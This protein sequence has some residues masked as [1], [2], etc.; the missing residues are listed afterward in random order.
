MSIFKESFKPGIKTQIKIRENALG[1]F[2]GGRGAE[3]M[4]YYNSRNA[5]I[6]MQS[7]V[8]V[9]GTNDLAKAYILQGGALTST[10]NIRQS[11]IGKEGA[12][13]TASPSGETYRLGIRP[14]PGITSIDVKS[15]SAFGSLRE[16]TVKYQCWDIKQLE[17]LELLYMRP[18]YTALVEWGWVPYLDNS[19]KLQST[20]AHSIP[21]ANIAAG[22]TKEAI[23]ND[24]YKYS[25]MTG[26]YDAVYGFIKNYQWSARADGGY[27]CTTTIITMGEILE[28]LKINYGANDTTAQEKGILGWVGTNAFLNID[29]PV[30]KAYAINI[31]AGMITEMYQAAI[32]GPGFE[33]PLANL[34]PTFGEGT[35]N[36]PAKGYA[37]NYG[38]FRWDLN[39]EHGKNTN[40]PFASAAQIYCRLKDF[41]D[42]LNKNILIHDTGANGTRTKPI[43]EISLEESYVHQAG[44]SPLLCLSHPFQLSTDPSV[45]IIKNDRWKDPK[46]YFGI[47]IPGNPLVDVMGGLKSTF[48][49]VNPTNPDA[50]FGIIGNIYVNLGFLYSLS[51]NGELQ[52][53]DKKEKN[54]IV[55][56]DYLKAVLA[57]VN[58][59][60]G[61]VANL[62][63]MVDPVDSVARIID[64]NYV[65]LRKRDDVYKD[66][67]TFELHNTRSIVRSYKLE[68]QIFPEQSTI[69]AIGA[70]SQGGALGAET[71]TMVDFN[72]GI[73]DRI[74]PKREAPIRISNYSDPAKEAEKRIQQIKN[75]LQ[76]I[77]KLILAFQPGWWSGEGSYNAQDS[78]K[79]ANAIKDIIQY[80]K[81]LTGDDNKN[82]AIIPTKLS[83]EIDGIGGII[84]GNLF[85]IPDEL[86][87]R[88]YKGTGTGNPGPTKMAYVVT[89]IGHS[90]QSNDWKTH[91]DAQVIL[92]DPP[93]GNY[94]YASGLTMVANILSHISSSGTPPPSIPR[95]LASVNQIILHD[96]AGYGNAAATVADLPTRGLSIHYAI[97]RAGNIARGT[98][99]DQV[100]QHAGVAN[101]HS[102]GIEICNIGYLKEVSG[103][104]EDEYAHDPSHPSTPWPKDGVA[105]KAH[106]TPANVWG[107]W[108]DLGWYLNRYRIYEEYSAAQIAALKTVIKEILTSCPNIHLNY[109][110][111]DLS[112]Y[113]NVFGLKSLTALPTAGQVVDTTRDYA[114]TNSGIFA[115]AV[116]STARADAHIGASMVAMLRQIKTETGR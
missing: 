87:P 45:C 10:G 52:A 4:Q 113:K 12:Y 30:P 89:G 24:I 82:R 49:G 74:V 47:D 95:T 109:T 79:Y 65:D 20:P 8:D 107:G 25:S 40:T 105:F 60:L 85:R 70:Q 115:H 101:T 97:D 99:L 13:D 37:P 100:A 83:M 116:I 73:I 72:K 46:T 111:D 23:W 88:G 11:Y 7:G 1:G 108:N 71:N 103:K 114:A 33:P 27:D 5:W 62:D 96:T 66:A 35:M 84:I 29:D 106:L 41:V 56:F 58:T 6:K 19:T 67:F 9:G 112:V 22:T 50:E 57:G 53:N 104:Y 21:L 54:D 44:G 94:S 51:H 69:V 75:S 61:N 55:I 38:F 43:V 77:T 81:S 36:I 2:L 102:V 18:G 86:L 28:S 34:P 48:F 59:A 3:A 98:P 31:L 26:N 90:I 93:K 78:S 68:S 80:I 42:L 76:T 64:V 16:V 110:D 39:I 92:L 17:D 32:A 63:V 14:M 91:L 15:K